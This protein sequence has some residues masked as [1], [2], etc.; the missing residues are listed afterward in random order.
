[1][2]LN[3]GAQSP[4]KDK[5]SVHSKGPGVME[6]TL[7]TNRNE[8]REGVGHVKHL[9]TYYLESFHVG[10]STVRNGPFI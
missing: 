5:G 7:K 6:R 10:I 9:E 2:R 4:G 1:M 3:T 8:T